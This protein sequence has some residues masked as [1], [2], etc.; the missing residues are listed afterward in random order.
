MESA[1]A[2]S[3]NSRATF[4]ASLRIRRLELLTLILRDGLNGFLTLAIKLTGNAERGDHRSESR[5]ADANDQRI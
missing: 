2:E 5:F 3:N 4:T 1:R